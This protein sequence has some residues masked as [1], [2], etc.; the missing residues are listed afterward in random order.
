MTIIEAIE[1]IDSMKPNQYDYLA[2]VKWLSDLDKTVMNEIIS[3]HENPNNLGKNFNGYNEETDQDI[4]LLA[5]EPYS[6]MYIQYLGMKI[7]YFNS[8]PIR[9][10]NSA[11]MF[12]SIYMDYAKWYNRNFKPL[13]SGKYKIF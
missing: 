5:Q 13:K 11:A 10:N 2:K 12:N 7:D 4:I 3:Q 8:E 1:T 9:Y 6:D